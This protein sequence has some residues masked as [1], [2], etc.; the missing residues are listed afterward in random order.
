M[1][2]GKEY[3]DIK[4][5]NFSVP[6]GGILSPTLINCYSSTIASRVLSDIGINA[7]ADDHSLQKDFTLGGPE[8]ITSITNLEQFEP[9]NKALD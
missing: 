5:F 4:T 6:Q 3:S 9:S 7:F 1:C 2:A 8:E